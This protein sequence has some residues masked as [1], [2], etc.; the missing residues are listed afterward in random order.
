MEISKNGESTTNSAYKLANQGE[1]NV[2]QFSGQWIWKLDILP[3]I[4]NFLWLCL[5]G[6]IPM[7][8][9]LAVRGINCDKLCSICREQDESII[10]LLW[11][12]VF[13]NDLWRKLKVPPSHVNPFADS[14]ETWLKTNSLSVVRH[15]GSIP[16]CTLFLFTVWTF[17]KNRNKV[18]FENSVPNSTLDKVCL[19]QAK[20]YFYCVSKAKQIAPTIAI[21]VKWS[22]PL[23]GWHKLNTDGV[24]LGNQS[25]A[26]SGGL[27]RDNEGRWI[28]GY[29]R[30]I[31]HMTSVMAELWA[32]RDGLNL[33]FQL[34]IRWLEV[35]LDAKVI[36]EMLNN[37]NSTNIKFSPLVFYYRS[38]IARFTQ[39]RVAHVYR[40]VNK[41]ADFLAKK[42]C[43][44]RENFVI[45]EVSPSDE[46][47]KLLVS[48]V[49]DLYCY[50]R[51]ATT[52]ASVAS[53]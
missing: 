44:M 10:H 35:E 15:K 48:D 14:L 51:V 3:R 22:K 17:W 20:E 9:V 11:D 26:C 4:T 18:V 27:I 25:K 16:W 36:V 50:R 13:P 23:P 30:S 40:E 43:C 8:E 47:D 33:A 42:G 46:L 29:S 28:R 53:L 39:V 32:L 7:K 5:H 38:L 31:G 21:P 37:A 45:F 52:L 2:T 6:S 19:S 49:N 24:S 34:G 1:E 41:C 12:C